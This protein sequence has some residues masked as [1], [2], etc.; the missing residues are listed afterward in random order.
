[1]CDGCSAFV[2]RR[3]VLSGLLAVT[4]AAGLG[5]KAA[6]A[7]ARISNLCEFS[8]PGGGI[9]RGFAAPSAQVTQALRDISRVLS[10]PMPIDVVRAEVETAAAF[11]D[12]VRGRSHFVVA[13]NQSFFDWLQRGGGAY[14]WMSVLAHEVGHHANGDTSWRDQNEN[15]WERELAADFTSGLC[16]ARL[17]ASPEQALRASQ[18]MY[19][20]MGSDSHPQSRLRMQAISAGWQ[21]GGGRRW[22]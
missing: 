20:R 21:K 13:Y 1:M 12:D 4:T 9:P 2:S 22:G 7:S 11:R 14:A 16:L 17:G 15:P 19:D 10:V 5:V 6:P 3:R 18:I 8:G